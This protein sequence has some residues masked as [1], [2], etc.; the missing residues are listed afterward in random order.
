MSTQDMYQQLATA[1]R[2]IPQPQVQ[3]NQVSL[4]SKQNMWND[5][6]LEAE[7]QAKQLE[8]P[9]E[10]AVKSMR[11]L[12]SDAASIRN[13]DEY[14]ATATAMVQTFSDVNNIVPNLSMLT[15]TN[16]IS[17]IETYGPKLDNFI[18]CLRRNENIAWIRELLAHSESDKKVRRS[19]DEL[20]IFSDES[21]KMFDILLTESIKLHHTLTNG[22]SQRANEQRACQPASEQD[23]EQDTT[24]LTGI[25]REMQQSLLIIDVNLNMYKGFLDEDE[26]SLI[27]IH[28]DMTG[29]LIGRRLACGFFGVGIGYSYGYGLY[30]LPPSFD[31]VGFRLLKHVVGLALFGSA[32]YS[33]HWILRKEAEIE[34]AW[35]I[36]EAKFKRQREEL[37][38]IEAKQNTTTLRQQQ[39][40]TTVPESNRHASVQNF[41]N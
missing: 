12:K 11:S 25:K 9:A 8:Q 10:A 15:L 26:I 33:I 20:K 21:K 3:R 16:A 2:Q 29:T 38:K 4:L 14:Q 19:F 24:L 18:T 41:Y 35:T 34:N 30:N 23:D 37:K 17:V 32:A 5:L 1:E 36:T 40:P 39:V 6:K 27:C 7:M 31:F 28:K 13:I 22:V